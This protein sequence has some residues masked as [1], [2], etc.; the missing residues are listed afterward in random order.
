MNS[1]AHSS[2]PFKRVPEVLKWSLVRLNGL[3]SV[4]LGIHSEVGQVDR[5]A[6]GLPF[7]ED[8]GFSDRTSVPQNRLA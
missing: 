2:N 7:F 5:P 3:Y 6:E 8:R 1:E 4:S